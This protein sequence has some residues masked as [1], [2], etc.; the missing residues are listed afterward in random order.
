[1][2]LAGRVCVVTGASSGIGRAVALSL[3]RAGGNVWAI[4]RDERRL[5]ELDT[6]I[7]S[8]DGRILPVSAD[9]HHSDRAAI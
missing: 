6:D 4:G 3:A 8:S 1:M 9:E 7:E 5:N 2:V